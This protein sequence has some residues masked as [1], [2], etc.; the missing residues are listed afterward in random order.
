VEDLP[1]WEVKCASSSIQQGELGDLD[2]WA[3]RICHHSGSI[4][5]DPLRLLQDLAKVG[6]GHH[7]PPSIVINDDGPVAGLAATQRHHPK[8]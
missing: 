5:P 8:K 6:G 7:S 1:A 3:F 4:L 2:V